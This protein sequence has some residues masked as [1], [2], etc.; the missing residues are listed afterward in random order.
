MANLRMPEVNNL[1]ISGNLTKDPVRRETS[2][3]TPVANF[4]LASN[5][6]YRDKANNWK[7]DVC[8]VG[9]VAW[10]K[11]ADSCMKYLKKGSAVLVEGELQSR[12][13]ENEDGSFRS[14]VEIKAKK[15]QFLNS[16]KEAYELE[17]EI[18]LET[19]V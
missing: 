2:G 7:E 15:I 17:K 18:E 10:N 13:F 12:N 1:M 11:L 6:K 3:G 4:Y 14:V 5:R 9:V 8:F 16:G 19:E